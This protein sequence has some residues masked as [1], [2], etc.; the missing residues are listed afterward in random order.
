VLSVVPSST[1]GQPLRHRPAPPQARDD[2]IEERP[3][4]VGKIQWPPPRV[5]E[6]KPEVQ[7]GRLDIEEGNEKNLATS[8]KPSADVIRQRLHDRITSARQNE[9]SSASALQ[10]CQQ[11]CVVRLRTCVNLLR[12]VPSSSRTLTLYHWCLSSVIRAAS[13]IFNPDHSVMSSV[14][15]IVCLPADLLPLTSLHKLTVLLLTLRHSRLI[16]L[17][18]DVI[19]A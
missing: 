1:A 8:M 16:W 19:Q 12:L 5:D 3:I 15:L 18:V 17:Y 6:A 14:D 7:V 13:L 11:R 2:M 10:V 4:R 9:P